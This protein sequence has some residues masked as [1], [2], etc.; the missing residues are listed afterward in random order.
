MMSLKTDSSLVPEVS[1]ML[2]RTADDGFSS[3][4][5]VYAPKMN[6]S[7]LSG[8]R[9]PRSARALREMPVRLG[10]KTPS[11]SRTFY[12]LVC[13]ATSNFPAA[14][15]YEAQLK[16]EKE[17][18][19]RRCSSAVLN[20]HRPSVFSAFQLF[21]LLRSLSISSDAFL[22]Q[23]YVP[24]ATVYPSLRKSPARSLSISVAASNGIG[25]R[26]A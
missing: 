5:K 13:L 16:A 19:T 25:L 6:V 22:T 21:G 9:N 2:P 23:H 14:R 4:C 11:T 17:Q 10:P 1:T 15:E 18:K 12:S 24:P 26:C 20:P 3:Q 8:V 7:T